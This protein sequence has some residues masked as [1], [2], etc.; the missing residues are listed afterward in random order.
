[1]MR[2]RYGLFFC[3]LPL[4]AGVMAM[5]LL[6]GCAR[7]AG[8]PESVAKLM[9]TVWRAVEVDGQRVEFLPGQKLDVSLVM[10]RTGAVRGAT[11]CN[12]LSGSF[13]QKSD[14]LSF[15]SLITTRMAGPKKLMV[16]ERLFLQ[17]LRR[18]AGWSVSG[19][20][21]TLYDDMGS[22]VARFMAVGGR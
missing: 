22:R 19:R 16:R 6:V 12:N 9:N 20:T 4:L 1:M 10:H 3:R 7:Q 18:T 2:A 15:S 17:A 8:S 5:L 13:S 14:R 21:L 11:G